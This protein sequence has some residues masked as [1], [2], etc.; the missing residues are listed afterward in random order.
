MVANHIFVIHFMTPK[1]YIWFFLYDLSFA[2]CLLQLKAFSH[3][4]SNIITKSVIYG[5]IDLKS[6][7]SV[8]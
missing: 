1:H 8:T 7:S 2:T 6:F 3:M 4:M 5:V